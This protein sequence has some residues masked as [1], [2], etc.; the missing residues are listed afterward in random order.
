[1]RIAVVRKAEKAV[2]PVAA[3][4]KV[5]QTAAE[6]DESGEVVEFHKKDEVAEAD[7]D[8]EHMVLRPVVAEL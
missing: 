5:E 1:M 3:A 6:P 2:T 8:R 4:R 7:D